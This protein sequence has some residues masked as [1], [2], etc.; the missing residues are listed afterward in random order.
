M[1]SVGLADIPTR[2][3]QLRAEL[4][5]HVEL[6]AVSKGAPADAIRAAYATGQ[7]Q[8]GE[9]RV[10]EAEAKQAEL[11]DLPDIVWHLIGHLQTNKAR[12]AVQVFGWIDS[13]DSLKLARRLEAVAAEAQQAIPICLQVK[14]ATDPTKYGWEPEALMEAL[15]HLS[16]CTH[17]QVRGLMAILPA[18]LTGDEAFD[19][20]SQLPRLRDRIRTAT[21]AKL[22]LAVLSMGMSGDYPWAI[23]AGATQVR[24]GS[25]IFR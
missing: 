12:K 11:I 24:I 15:P 19:L 14:L 9:S 20:F 13:V 8:F 23:R 18:G 25:T 5:S 2:I 21:G 3:A 6:V 22:D 17:L 10:Q 16:Q 1:T 4:P 7:R